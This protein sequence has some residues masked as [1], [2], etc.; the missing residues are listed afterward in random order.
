MKKSIFIFG[1][2]LI[3]IS[4]ISVGYVNWNKEIKAPE[5]TQSTFIDF[6]GQNLFTNMAMPTEFV[7]NVDS[8]FINTVT[9]NQLISAKSIEDIL[10]L[11]ATED[12][13][14]YKDVEVAILSGKNESKVV[15]VDEK[16][17]PD[18]LELLQ[19]T[20][21]S[22]DIYIYANYYLKQE[23][24][25]VPIPRRLTYYITIL[26]EKEAE[27]A[28]GNDAMI[29]YLKENSKV[30]TANIYKD[31]LKPGRIK[32]TVSKDGIISKTKLTS[33]SGYP[34]LDEK[35]EQLISTLP[36]KWNPATN[37]KGEKVDQALVFF[38]GMQGC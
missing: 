17:T 14:S 35:M 29:T 10:P 32:F 12:V 13:S 1:A 5:K 7:Y 37:S 38:F 33:T 30:E 16:L 25:G 22:N 34:T 3:A 8:R 4:L 11:R 20:D 36:G 27:F 26:P 2:F 31:K 6:A 21:Y 23:A 15:G 19:S 28:K 9:R 24:N 18:Q